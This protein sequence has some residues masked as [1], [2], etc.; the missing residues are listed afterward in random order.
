LAIAA[1]IFFLIKEVVDALSAHAAK[2][3]VDQD[4]FRERKASV[5]YKG[6]D[7]VVAGPVPAHRAAVASPQVMLECRME[8]LMGEHSGQLCRRQRCN[9]LRVVEQGDPVGSHRLDRGGL[10]PFKSE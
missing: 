7:G 3:M 6:V 1:L 2:A 9:E 10:A 5:K 4:I 8:Y